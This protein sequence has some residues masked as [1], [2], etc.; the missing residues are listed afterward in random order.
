[1]KAIP[2]RYRGIEYRS[3]LEARW[4]AFFDQ[5][6]W[7][8]T[9][10][11]FDLE[12][13]I[14]DFLIHGERPLL[15]EVKP[16]ATVEDYRAPI[17]KINRALSG[18]DH[19]DLVIVGINPIT[20]TLIPDVIRFCL[21]AAGVVTDDELNEWD[22]A[23]WFHCVKCKKTNIHSC[24]GSYAGRPCGHHDGDHHIRYIDPQVINH[25]WANACNDVKWRAV[26]V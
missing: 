14:P 10:E 20:Q 19:K 9:Y 13:Y 6:S 17:P 25:Y 7:Q 5:L 11:P 22:V 16:A 18:S 2:T 4:A 3:R 12:G 21:S 23:L 8:H 1:M 24:L 26:P 15:V